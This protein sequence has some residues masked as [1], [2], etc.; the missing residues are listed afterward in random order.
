AAALLALGRPGGAAPAAEKRGGRVM[1]IDAVVTDPAGRPVTGLPRDAFRVRIDRK[2]MDVD[3]FAA[4]R[5]GVVSPANLETLSPDLVLAPGGRE[6]ESRVPRHFLLW[7]DESALT[8][9]RRRHAIAAL[10]DFLA[11]LG[12]SDEAAVV[13]ERSRPETL[14]AWTSRPDA[15]LAAL[16]AVAARTE[17]RRPS[18][19]RPPGPPPDADHE[20]RARAAE[21]EAGPAS[22]KA[23]DDLSE[24]L[25]LFADKAG[26]KVVIAVSEALEL[27]PPDLRRVI[28][29]ANAI[30]AVVFTVDA[31][32]LGTADDEIG[33]RPATRADPDAALVRLAEETGGEAVVR[34][35]DVEAGLAGILRDVSTYYALGIDLKNVPADASARIDVVVERPGLRVHARRTWTPEDDASRVE[36]RVR[37]TLLTSAAYADL[38]PVVRVGPPAR[39]GNRTAVAIDVEVAPADVTFVPDAGHAAAQVVYF[40]SARSDRGEETPL[41]RTVQ[42]F[43]LGPAEVR[44]ATPLV[45]RVEL[46]FGKG[47]WRLVVN[48]LDTASGR[49]GTA[50]ATIRAE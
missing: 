44:T 31:R 50:R 13:A 16:D 15:L 37:T 43:R 3:Y 30:E 46:K 34:G 24:S 28:D 41:T 23:L 49:M 47:V 36:D 35:A 8:P 11:R 19:E 48:V 1:D 18:A 10:R 14:A 29:R 6:E 7:I 32:I 4:V 42:S 5:D 40:F 25:A 17:V 38:A 33:A 20:P 22:R 9:A 26:K 45:E 21:D 2:E 12:P 39:E 27:P